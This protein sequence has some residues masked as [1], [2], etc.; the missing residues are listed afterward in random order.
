MTLKLSY[1]ELRNTM[2]D[3][4]HNYMILVVECSHGNLGTKRSEHSI[5]TAG[6]LLYTNTCS[7]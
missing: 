1:A 5:L 3:I 4:N 7:L 6:A 2:L